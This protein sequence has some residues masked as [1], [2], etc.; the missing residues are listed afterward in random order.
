MFL[1][2]K[3]QN[4]ISTLPSFLNMHANCNFF[5][6]SLTRFR[7][8]LDRISICIVE[9]VQNLSLFS[10]TQT[11]KIPIS[12]SFLHC[13]QFQCSWNIY[14]PAYRSLLSRFF[15]GTCT[16]LESFCIAVEGLLLL[17]AFVLCPVPF[18]E[19]KLNI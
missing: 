19:R 15:S 2:K 5:H 8:N 16:Y 1:F 12:R 11:C 14:P 3:L 6:F 7:Q 18:A 4:A 9:N 10:T 13:E 17:P